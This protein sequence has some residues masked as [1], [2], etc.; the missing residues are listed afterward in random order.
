MNL[1]IKKYINKSRVIK[2]ALL[3]LTCWFSPEVANATHIV[4]GEMRYKCVGLTWY[5]ITLVI[6]RD[7][8]NGQEPFDNPAL[9]G[10]FTATDNQ[11]AWRVGTNGVVKLNLVS[12]R[13]VTESLDKICIGPGAEVCV[14]EATYYAKIPL[15][16]DERGFILA[17]Q[18]C[19]RNTTLTNIE[20]P[21]EVGTTYTVNI[22]ADD[23]QNCN[24]N[25]V[26]KPFP[27]IYACLNSQ[28]TYDHSAV[29]SSADSLVYTLCTPYLGRTRLDPVGAPSFPPY[30][31]V[32]YKAPFSINNVFGG[33]P[34]TINR[35][36]GMLSGTPDL[37]G[38]YLIGVC[39]EEY[40]NGQ[41]K[42][43]TRRDFELNVVPCGIKPTAS[44][45]RNT[46]LCDG[47]KQSFT[48][49]SQLTLAHKWFFDFQNDKT[50]MSTDQNPMHLYSKGGTYEVVLV[51]S[52]GG[53]TD[54]ARMTITVLDLALNPDFTFKTDCATDGVKFNLTN[55][56]TSNYPIT[57][58]NW[59]VTGTGNN[60]TSMDKDPVFDFSN[61][62]GVRIMLTV[63]D[64][65]G[66]T[67]SISKDVTINFIDIKLKASPLSLCKGDSVRL[68]ENPDPK[69][70]YTWSPT[71]NLILNP[72]SNPLAFPMQN[73]TYKVTITD[74]TCTV[75]RSVDIVIR[76]R[77]NLR[78]MGDTATCD[79]KVTLLASSDSTNVFEWAT[80]GNFNPIIG[81]SAMLNTTI[82]GT[83][84]FYVRAGGS[85]QCPTIG[86]FTVKDNSINLSY[87][88]EQT[89]CSVDTFNLDVRNTDPN[90]ILTISW[91]GDPIII[92]PKNVLNPTIYCSAP[93]KYRLFF[94]A[95]N[96]F[97][98][99]LV[100]TIVITA[101]T[102]PNPDFTIEYDC[103]S[104]TVKVV[105]AGGRKVIWDFGDG[106]GRGF[107]PMMMYT[108]EKSGNYKI[109]LMVDSICVR[110]LTKELPVVLI[111][112]DLQDRVVSCHGGTVELNPGG[113]ADY[114]Y[115]W[116]PIT[117]LDN[118]KVP[119]PKATVSKTT[120]YHV[121]INDPR[122]PGCTKEDS[123]TVFVPDEIGLV[124]S[125][126]TTLCEKTKIVLRANSNG[127]DISYK[128]CD[129]SGKEIGTGKE[130][131][132]EPTKSTF[133]VVK[134]TD[135]HNCVTVDTIRV[136]LF[137]LMAEISGP[138]NICKGAEDMIMVTAA[139]GTNYTYDWK[140]KEFINGSSNTNVIKIKPNT[141]TTFTV[142][143]SNGLGCVWTLS[144]SVV[145]NDPSLGIFAKADPDLV[146]P[147]AKTQLTTVENPN[148]TYKWSPAEGLSDVNI[149]NPIATPTKTTTYTVTV[150]DQFGCTATAS[151]TVKVI[152]CEESLFVPNAFSPNGDS[153]NDEFRVRSNFITDIEIVVYNRW[154]QEMYKAKDAEAGWN[155]TFNGEKL[156]PDVFG[157]C[158]IYTC[159]D[160][161]KHTKLG[162]VSIIK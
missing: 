114:E 2:L 113:S 87:S 104:L 95:T 49:T 123:I 15:P 69:Y 17:Y 77:V 140:P 117:G 89:I 135:A 92:G 145:V 154:G 79:G 57:K 36:T 141:N 59:T 45:T 5:E 110:S 31:P 153:K 39:V 138:A 54:T 103:G 47:L 65:N 22:S 46:N 56:T 21:L 116:T 67:A 30:S 33:V 142:E 100:D 80:N 88:K 9:V 41:L 11:L 26:F 129:E 24:S 18:R 93:G 16:F 7:C 20:D 38:Q 156:G 149:F 136:N 14:E 19:C 35:R 128:W 97:G 10:A 106:K 78:I 3:L 162:N 90:D 64:S 160:N 4:G 148:Y 50:L 133:Y 85:N 1:Q 152:S 158:V 120:T 12:T 32:I 55:T 139:P 74:G 53:C 124:T 130:I 40:K 86:T 51:A 112:V 137:E 101:V 111:N 146:V 105:T 161:T 96:Q 134:A 144:H 125:S 8:V 68:V 62:G 91:D 107:D 42:T 94:T 70:T 115:E 84:T 118:A 119:N 122:F 147:G 143:I 102:P 28:F 132:V 99:K 37:V 71:T 108:Y 44:F 157:Y 109:T 76:E 151:V 27:P 58:Y 150:T 155:G 63:T 48:S 6:R 98:C 61:Q 43:Y 126:D 127:T 159:P 13:K 72:P 25:P 131:T 73:T 52:N 34:L 60:K 75:E 81:R 82:N 121:L 83:T 23:L 29:D 66:C